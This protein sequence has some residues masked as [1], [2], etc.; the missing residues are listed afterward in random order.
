MTKGTQY[1]F[2]VLS[3]MLEVIVN[4]VFKYVIACVSLSLKVMPPQKLKDKNLVKLT[5]QEGEHC[6]SCGFSCSGTTELK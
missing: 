1:P 6:S 3:F 4:L 2:E 5:L